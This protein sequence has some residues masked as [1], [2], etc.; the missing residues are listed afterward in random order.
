MKHR[1]LI[2]FPERLK[3]M[4]TIAFS[5][6]AWTTVSSIKVGYNRCL[7]L[8]ERI[9]KGLGRTPSDHVIL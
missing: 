4:K 2:L 9:V 5:E 8:A 7:N 1:V 3:I 6:P